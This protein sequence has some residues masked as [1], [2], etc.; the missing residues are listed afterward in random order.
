MPIGGN[1]ELK[2][3]IKPEVTELFDVKLF[4]DLKGGRSIFLRITGTVEYPS[5]S[6][7]EVCGLYTVVSTDHESS[8]L[9]MHVGHI[10][11]WWC[12]LWS[13][14]NYSIHHIQQGITKNCLL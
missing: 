1:V 6:I 9:I 2:V 5:V 10:S 4:I 8:A 12:L 14:S 11:V 7:S 13:H 3:T